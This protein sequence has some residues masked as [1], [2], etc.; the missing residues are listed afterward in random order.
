MKISERA[1]DW[2]VLTHQNVRRRGIGFY[3]IAGAALFVGS[4]LAAAAVDFYLTERANQ[5]KNPAAIAAGFTDFNDMDEANAAGF[6][7]A[8]AWQR[9]K[10][11]RARLKEK[12]RAD[13]LA[14]EEKKRAALLE[15]TRDPTDRMKLRNGSWSKGGFGSVG[16]MNVIITND[17]NFAVKDMTILCVFNA[18]SGTTLSE[19]SYTIYDTVDPKASKAFRNL[20]VGFIDS[21]SA[22]AGCSLVSAKR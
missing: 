15:A 8:V 3:V 14:E 20:N 10:A 11:E 1:H 21:Q 17:N 13:R 2:D 16:M 19:R 9:E 22:R 5:A 7:D 12:E 4:F 6:S 18:K